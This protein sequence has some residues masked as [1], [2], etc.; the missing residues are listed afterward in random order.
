[1]KVMIIDDEAPARVILSHMLG[2]FPELD[3]VAEAENGFEAIKLINEKKPDLIFLDIQMPKI[4]GFELLEVLEDPPKVIFVTA[5][6][7]YAL[8]A[9]EKGAVDY[10]LKPINNERLKYAVSRVRQEYDQ[11]KVAKVAEEIQLN[12]AP[13]KQIVVK[14]G[15]KIE[16]IPCN[17]VEFIRAE[18][19]Y[20]AIHSGAKEHLKKIPLSHL[21]QNLDNQLFIRV[22]R[23]FIL[24][25]NHLK[26]I[27]KW[28]RDQYMGFTHSGERIKISKPGYDKLKELLDF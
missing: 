22:H 23:S 14:D 25:I 8:K 12:R 21:E 9:F 19:D 3:I 16:V 2:D 15:K 4:N 7:E 20:V 5:F 26:N 1:M 24:N 27:E 13:L 11:Q 28:T 10:L 6:D 17:E 18:D